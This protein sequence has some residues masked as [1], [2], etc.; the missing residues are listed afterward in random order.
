MAE[1][2]LCYLDQEGFCIVRNERIHRT[3]ISY[4]TVSYENG[5]ECIF[6]NKVLKRSKLQ[7]SQ[8]KFCILVENN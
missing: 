3:F 2:Q 4:Y 5:W 7:P 1:L 8:P 6:L